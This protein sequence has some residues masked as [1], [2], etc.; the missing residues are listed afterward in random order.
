MFLK[1]F[2][3]GVWLLGAASFSIS[4]PELSYRCIWLTFR[5]FVVVCGPFASACTPACTFAKNTIGLSFGMKLVL[6]TSFWRRQRNCLPGTALEVLWQPTL[7]SSRGVECIGVELIA[8]I[9]DHSDVL[10]TH[11][12]TFKVVLKNQ[13]YPRGEG[14][15]RSVIRPQEYR[16]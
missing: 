5:P 12:C 3:L 14:L 2:V 16:S 13:V 9:F 7:R 10:S 4:G 8:G 6:G 1:S 11:H 15:L